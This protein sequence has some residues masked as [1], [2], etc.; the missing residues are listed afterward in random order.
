MAA[1]AIPMLWGRGV[2]VSRWKGADGEGAKTLEKDLQGLEEF[3]ATE[4]EISIV[5]DLLN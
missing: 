4:T 5:T 3:R 2:R 1:A